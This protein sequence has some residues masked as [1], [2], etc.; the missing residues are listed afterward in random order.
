MRLWKSVSDAL[1]WITGVS[2]VR[3]QAKRFYRKVCVGKGDCW[4][5]RQ[6]G[7]CIVLSAFFLLFLFD[8]G[9]QLF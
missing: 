7:D 8:D 5:V 4:K 3:S 1:F 6:K 2:V 9:L